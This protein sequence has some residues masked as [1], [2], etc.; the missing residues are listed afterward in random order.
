MFGSHFHCVGYGRNNGLR[1]VA[2]II[3]NNIAILGTLAKN[4]PVQAG[5]F[6]LGQNSV[7]H[8]Q[9]VGVGAKAKKRQVV[10]S[11]LRALILTQRGH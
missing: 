6:V 3:K 2:F 9:S 8:K 4:A 5:V 11:C 7:V 1:E 10:A